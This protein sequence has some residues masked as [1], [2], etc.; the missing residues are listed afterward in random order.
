MNTSHISAFRSITSV[1]HHREW[2]TK[3]IP[4]LMGSR[5]EECNGLLVGTVGGICF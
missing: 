1:V 5:M 2:Q 3:N 4:V